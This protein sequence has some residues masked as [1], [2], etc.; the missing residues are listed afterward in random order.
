MDREAPQTKFNSIYRGEVVNNNDLLKK[1]RIQIKVFGIFDEIPDEA[2]PWAIY[3]DPFMG[4]G[5]DSG[6]FFIPD[7]GDKVWCF[8]ENGDHHQPVYFAGSPSAMDFPDE[9]TETSHEETQGAVEYPKNRVFKTK[10][11]HILEFDDSEGNQRI[12]IKHK[13]GTQYTM[14]DNGDVYEHITGNRKTLIDGDDE[15]IIT[16]DKTVTVTGDSTETISGSQTISVSGDAN[17][18]YSA[19]VTEDVGGDRVIQAG[20]NLTL[21][22]GGMVSIIGSAIALN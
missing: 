14:Q 18:S 12:T 16:G 8:F 15:T 1:G 9:S 4:G 10:S 5:S 6:G 11:G 2:L 19:G 20:G 21:F 17:H 13:S 22:S 3:A 7:E